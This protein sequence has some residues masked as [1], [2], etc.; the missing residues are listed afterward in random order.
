MWN[1]GYLRRTKPK[2]SRWPTFWLF[3]NSYFSPTLSPN[4]VGLPNTQ[5]P[6][7][8]SYQEAFP[9]HPSPHPLPLCSL[10]TLYT[11]SGHFRAWYFLFIYVY[12]I[13]PTQNVNSMKTGNVVFS[14]ALRTMHGSCG[15]GGSCE[16][17]KSC[18]TLWPHGLQHTR[19]PCPSL[20]PRACSNSHPLSQ[21]CHPTISTSVIPFLS[22]PQS[23]PASRSFP[24]NRLFASGGQNIEASVSAPVLPMNI[25]IFRVYFL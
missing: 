21:W 12:C 10:T 20:T 22:C 3:V 25:W 5:I 11:S 17:T 8:V 23:F 6:L 14:P 2:F 19:L 16:V 7:N 1:S 18:Q 13:L 9:N 24:M 15:G 4:S